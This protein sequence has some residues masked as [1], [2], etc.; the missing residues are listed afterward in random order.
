MKLDGLVKNI[1]L[2]SLELVKDQV[3][4]QQWKIEEQQEKEEMARQ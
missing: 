1:I 4:I 2:E 3:K